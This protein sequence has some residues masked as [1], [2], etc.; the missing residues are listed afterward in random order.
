MPRVQ[1]E[2][3]AAGEDEA[4]TKV[5]S[6]AQRLLI[7]VRKEVRDDLRDTG[8]A[9]R[10]LA[11]V[12]MGC[13]FVAVYGVSFLSAFNQY[14]DT[15]RGGSEIFSAD[16]YPQTAFAYGLADVSPGAL[17][18][19]GAD[20]SAVDDLAQEMVSLGFATNEQVN[21]ASGN[22]SLD[23]FESFLEAEATPDNFAVGIFVSQGSPDWAYSIIVN[24]SSL[25]DVG[26][27]SST[28]Y[29]AEWMA[30]RVLSAQFAADQSIASLEGVASSAM[31]SSLVSYVQ[32][33]PEAGG[34]D[35]SIELIAL[36]G[37][38]ILLGAQ[39]AINMYLV[40]MMRDK[41]KGVVRGL[42]L[43]GVPQAVYWTHWVVYHIIDGAL[44]A[45]LMT[46]FF[47][48]CRYVVLANG[49]FV[50]FPFFLFMI[51]TG[52]FAVLIT[53]VVNT[54][55]VASIVPFMAWLA[56]SGVSTVVIIANVSNAVFS[57]LTFL[58]PWFGL[59]QVV[60]ILIRWDWA[61]KDLG[62]D[63]STAI[64]SGMVGA[65]C[66]QIAQI[67]YYQTL[68]LWK[69]RE[70]S[71][72]KRGE[73]I[74]SEPS[75]DDLGA[76][77]EFEALPQNTEPL[78]RIRG[79][80]KEFSLGSSGMCNKASKTVKAVNGLD[81]TVLK[82]EIFGFL[83]HNSSGKTTTLKMIAG[84]Y[85]P[86]AGAAELH[87]AHGTYRVGAGADSEIRN[88]IGVCAQEDLLF[89]QMTCREHLELFARLKGGIPCAAGESET[90]AIAAEVQRRIDQVNFTTPSDVDKPVSTYSG[91]MKRKVS[92]AVAF[93]GN[94]ELV[95]LDEPTAGV[96][97]Y[98]RRAIWDMI[99]ASKAG[100]SIILTT[101]FMDEADVLSDRIGIL[102]HGKLVTCGTS[103]FL[104]H[105]FGAGYTLK[106]D[107]PNKSAMDATAA[108]VRSAV[109]G[110]EF[111][112]SN[113]LTQ[114]WKLPTGAEQAFAGLLER[115][116][117][118]GCAAVSL[119]LT[120]LTDVFLKTGAEDPSRDEE[121]DEAAASQSTE[122]RFLTSDAQKHMNEAGSD[123]HIIPDM[124]S[125]TEKIRLIWTDPRDAS[126][127]APASV[128]TWKKILAISRALYKQS[129][130]FIEFKIFSV[131][132]PMA[133][134]VI[135]FVL[136]YV[137]EESDE[138]ITVAPLSLNGAAFFEAA[139][140]SSG[141]ASRVF[142]LPNMAVSTQPAGNGNVIS[143]VDE[144][145]PSA[146]DLSWYVNQGLVAGGYLSTNSTLMYNRTVSTSLPLMYAFLSNA[147][148]GTI[149][150]SIASQVRGLPYPANSSGYSFPQFMLALFI[151]FGFVS[152]G[153]LVITLAEFKEARLYTFCRLHG[154]KRLHVFIAASLNGVVVSWLPFFVVCLIFAFG[155]RN[156]IVG[157][158]GRGLAFF[159]LSVS[160]A[161]AMI[162]FG[163]LF[164]P[165]FMTAEQARNWVPLIMI[166]LIAAPYAVYGTMLIYTTVE[167][168]QTVGDIISFL[169]GF[170]F[171]R[172]LSEL[173]AISPKFN[174]P[175]LTWADTWGWSARISYSIVLL[176]AS[177]C[178]YW[179]MV[180]LQVRHASYLAVPGNAEGEIP[181]DEDV[182]RERELAMDGVAAGDKMLRVQDIV[183]NF[184]IAPDSMSYRF[185]FLDL[186]YW[187]QRLFTCGADPFESKYKINH[188]VKGLS[189]SVRP[190]EI[191][192]LLG[193]NGSGKSVTA[194]SIL[195]DLPLNGGDV[196]LDGISIHNVSATEQLYAEGRVAYCPQ[197]DAVF[198]KLNVAEHVDFVLAA[199]GL[200]KKDPRVA[201]HVSAVLDTLNLT[202]HLHKLAVDLSGGYKRRLCLALALIDKAEL[203][204]ID[205][206]SSGIDPAGRLQLWNVLKPE[207]AIRNASDA[208]RVENLQ[209]PGMLLSTHYMDEAQALANKIGIMVNGSM[210][211]VG[212]LDRLRDKHCSKIFVDLTFQNPAPTSDEVEAAFGKADFDASIVEVFQ[213]RMKLQINFEDHDWSRV[214]MARVLASAFRFVES[215]KAALN[216]ELYTLAVMDL[217][218]IFIELSKEQ[219]DRESGVVPG[220]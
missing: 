45:A 156:P 205:E 103:L 59:Y 9:L 63:A 170:S 181:A 12:V 14:G 165:L 37:L 32:G 125:L 100:R 214:S 107:A 28:S 194:S 157:N 88:R 99:A 185:R 52:Q 53:T 115:L 4:R 51:G 47:F 86:T 42:T 220:I 10:F 74:P 137:Y 213:N 182:A 112:Y 217:E 7:L 149:G 110:A 172:G 212:S 97:S 183:K 184:R 72:S 79:L 207:L 6:S 17:I 50:F 197:H 136:V 68:I 94:P 142:D 30:S 78:L 196:A 203:M 31:A 8:S 54:D 201:A 46:V 152:L 18:F 124:D 166:F 22:S 21:L 211:T 111:K 189:F 127:G 167:V 133:Y 81:M 141:S 29:F 91:G 139:D 210:L 5:P 108:S 147:S 116:D 131:A 178:F 82:G 188:A 173:F 34:N 160:Y 171:Q 1:A 105:H 209:L 23:A 208:S 190:N 35:I 70:G 25:P 24:G 145:P 202:Q 120:T 146:N 128:S 119:E 85:P 77:P 38:Y 89:D 26:S 93:L 187:F 123:E 130:R 169:P 67:I 96:D 158:G 57:V 121:G 180:Y 19:A 198:N 191:F 164:E 199:H 129:L 179:I 114:H 117:G 118:S 66:A 154:I 135:A 92:I 132:M 43:M 33:L 200:D 64:E 163:F 80:R 186:G 36:P 61:G 84:E 204:L 13:V 95:M 122:D 155:F 174:D 175:A 39:F 138:V 40:P 113:Q 106:F 134:I 143:F 206:V 104:K 44:I 153:Y 144:A 216:I 98:G 215:A 218:K 20:G 193:P 55:T 168:Q 65:I 16:A 73:S 140:I 151:G 161:F 219:F 76:R 71:S 126:P 148:L 69:F 56:F 195:R 102:N 90:E 192:A 27:S 60:S 41:R 15:A 75:E 177:G 176:F 62:V 159:L 101:H 150:G 162:P 49:F 48:V 83:G 109:P 87:F 2:P 11:R 3:K 58:H